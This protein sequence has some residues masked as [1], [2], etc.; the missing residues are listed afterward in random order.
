L[1]GT[2]RDATRLIVIDEVHNLLGERGRIVVSTSKLS[3]GVNV[4]NVRHVCI[5][6]AGTNQ[7]DIGILP[8]IDAPANAASLPVPAIETMR[9]VFIRVLPTIR[10]AGTIDQADKCLLG[11][12][13]P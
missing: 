12:A 13:L 7:A 5:W 1:R 9:D 10:T 3:A 2:C 4:P 8:R 11:D 6:S